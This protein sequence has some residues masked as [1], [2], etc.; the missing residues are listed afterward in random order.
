MP[1][2]D[3][4]NPAEYKE[5]DAFLRTHSNG[6]FTQSLCWPEV[7]REE[8]EALYLRDANGAVTAAAIVMVKR[9]PLLKRTLLY[10]PR[11]PVLQ[12]DDRETAAALMQELKALGREKRAYK[13][14][15]DPQ[16][17]VTDERTIRLIES[18][19]Y[20]LEKPS[21]DQSGIFY[22]L[23][24]AGRSPEELLASFHPKW[25]YNIRLAMRRGVTCRACGAE[26]LEE[27]YPIWCETA[28]RDGF[29]VR[30]KQYLYRYMEAFGEDCRLYLCDYQGQALS[31][32]LAVRY[33]GKVS[34]VFGG[35]SALH[36]EV[37]PN[38]LM[39]FE[40]IRWAAESGCGLYDFG[41]L[42]AFRGDG[43]DAHAGVYG[44][45]RGFRGEV[46][47]YT[48]GFAKVESRAVDTV[49]R[50]GNRAVG[51]LRRAASM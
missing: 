29:P 44:F 10:V 25:R 15:L 26:G 11:G 31:G 51:G 40:M 12:W 18:F 1:L 9:V 45:K 20:A 16:I 39:Q 36:R 41:G 38:Y 4:G 49:L 34:Y 37:M 14:V 2:M 13:I 6:W 17:R 48:V 50:L 33:A 3:K 8:Y 43:S 46:V 32:A 23:P 21:T 35:S 22:V 5:I 19:S 42:P 47:A 28:R 7:K 24:L 27:F 30:S